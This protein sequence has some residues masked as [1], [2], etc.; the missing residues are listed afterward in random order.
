VRC[1]IRREFFVVELGIIFS[2]AFVVGL[3][4]AMMPGPLLTVTLG[5]SA[6]R[7]F[8]A[9]PLIVFGHGLLE[10]FLVAALAFGLATFLAASSLVKVI[11]GGGGFFLIYLGWSMGKDVLSGKAELDFALGGEVG[12]QS[13][14]RPVRVSGQGEG[15]RAGIS[16]FGGDGC[17]LPERRKGFHPVLAGALVSL[18]NPYWSLWWATVGVSYITFSLQKGFFGLASFFSGHLLSDFAWYSLVAAVVAGGRR[19]LRPGVY[20]GMMIV[21]GLFLIGLG[22][23]FLSWA[24]LS[25]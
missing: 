4:G 7:G 14:Q 22:V 8:S 1:F 6:R 10:G 2:T 16:E 20:K 3:S 15:L 19:F 21:C 24:L 17:V 9:G 18:S 23:Y 5:E 11:A 25:L 13:G 12:F